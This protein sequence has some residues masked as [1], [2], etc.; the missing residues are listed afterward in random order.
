MAY[1]Q[2][3]AR[4]NKATVNMGPCYCAKHITSV[5][6]DSVGAAV[7]S[8]SDNASGDVDLTTP[9]IISNIDDLELM[10]E[11]LPRFHVV[12]NQ[13]MAE[14]CTLLEFLQMHAQCL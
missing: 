9:Q 4:C 7:A 1:V 6:G 3:E 10:R 12:Q 5:E 13:C 8:S 2:C 14:D 11:P